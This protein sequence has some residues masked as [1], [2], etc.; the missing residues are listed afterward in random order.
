MRRRD[1]EM[2]EAF[3]RD[4]LARCAWATVAMIA[5][6]GEPYCVPLSVA[7][8][9]DALYFHCALEGRKTACLRHCPR[10]WVV[11]VGGTRPRPDKFSV[12]YESA[13]ARGLAEEVTDEAG[14]MHALRLICE[15]H[16]AENI[17]NWEDEARRFFSRT[18][19]WKIT[20]SEITGKRIRYA[21][22]EGGERPS[23]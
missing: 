19:V 7:A 20:L 9:G 16:A 2:P 21:P 17:A 14:R 12:E 15:R 4:V 8:E 5:P 3:G 6:E 11:G 1:H 18:A 13:M 10:V 23:E 22:Q